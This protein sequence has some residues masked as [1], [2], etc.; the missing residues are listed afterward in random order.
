MPSVSASEPI[1]SVPLSLGQKARLL[2]QVVP[3]AFFA[4][5]SAIYLLAFQQ[6]YGPPPLPFVSFMLVVLLAVGYGVR[7]CLLDVLAGVAFVRDDAV[8]QRSW[9]SYGQHWGHHGIF[10]GLG[11]MRMSPKAFHAGVVGARHR[12]VY[13]PRSRLVWSVEPHT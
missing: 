10:D 1:E 5:L 8:L 11:R 6:S 2:I 13:S 7:G 12:V 3:L 9:T 4:S